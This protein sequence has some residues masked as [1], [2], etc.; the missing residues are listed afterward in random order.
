MLFTYSRLYL[1]YTESKS[2]QV[3]HL[4]R[5]SRYAAFYTILNA[6]ARHVISLLVTLAKGQLFRSYLV[7]LLLPVTKA[8][9]EFMTVSW[10]K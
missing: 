6:S 3:G 1:K 7:R 2:A 4:H 8:G 10:P 5:P 9:K